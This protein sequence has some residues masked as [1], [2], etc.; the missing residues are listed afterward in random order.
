MSWFDGRYIRIWTSGRLYTYE[1]VVIAER[2]LGK[3][4]PIGAVVHHIDDDGR[5]NA[6]NNLVL[7][8][9]HGYHALLH[10]RRTAYRATRDANARQCPYC[11]GWISGEVPD[12]FISRRVA[13]HRKCELE[14][15]RRTH[16]H[17]V[18]GRSESLRRAW[19]IRRE[20]TGRMPSED[21]GA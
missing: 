16:V 4:L 19:K 3:S 8:E 21:A 9:N 7:C 15:Q 18:L 5:N 6:M 11:H 12:T 1:H 20:F 10:H 13:Y 17:S 14:Y 2:A